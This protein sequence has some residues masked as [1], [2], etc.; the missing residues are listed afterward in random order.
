MWRLAFTYLGALVGAGFASGQELLRFF[1]VYGVKGIGGALVAGVLLGLLGYLALKIVS[2]EKIN[3]YGQFLNY[4]F[5]PYWGLIMDGFLSLF[6]LLS[7][8]VML[9][10]GGSLG[11][12]QGLAFSWGFVLTAFFTGWVLLIGKEGVLWLNTFL[13]PG[14][15]IL[16]ILISLN[17][18]LSDLEI[19]RVISRPD[20]IG[21]NWLKALFLYAAYNFVLGASLLASLGGTDQKKIKGIFWGGIIFGG[22]AALISG[23]LYQKLSLVK[24]RSLPFL[25]LAQA[26]AP[27]WAKLYAFFLWAA[28]FTTALGLGWGLVKRCERLIRAP[29][30]LI[31]LGL[32]LLTLP[33]LAWSLPEMVEFVYPFI[34]YG[35]LVLGAGLLYKWFVK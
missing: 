28:I 12:E 32:F 1:A 3:D 8:A 30:W 10:A 29:R 21:T 17:S 14:L 19:V 33:F 6:L 11:A 23:A 7:L 35:G 25:V 31:L 2:K 13:I 34:G 18:L 22:I 27:A 20:L 4:L 5:G 15:L 16:T 24:F 9:V 26:F